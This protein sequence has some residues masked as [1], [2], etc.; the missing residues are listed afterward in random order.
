MEYPG[1]KFNEKTKKYYIDTTIKLNNGKLFHVKYKSLDSEFGSIKYVK[2]NYYRI[3]EEI[4]T[5]KNNEIAQGIN[6]IKKPKKGQPF[7]KVTDLLNEYLSYRANQLRINT[8][9]KYELM[10]YNAIVMPTEDKTSVFLSSEFILK[11]RKSIL[12]KDA[13]NKTKSLYF[14]VA[15]ELITFARKIDLI[16]SDK[17]DD[18]L[19]LLDTKFG[20][21]KK[22]ECANKYTPIEDAYK[23]FDAASNDYY[24][25]LFILLYYSS[26]RIGEFLGILKEDIKECKDENNDVYYEIRINKQRLPSSVL[27]PYLK[28]SVP[29]KYIYYFNKPAEVLKEYLERANLKEKDYLFDKSRTLIK[30][31]LNKAFIKANVPHNTLHGFGR[32]SINTELYKN[33][34]DSKT[35]S[36]LLGQ[37]SQ[38]INEIHYVENNEAIKKAKQIL[39]KIE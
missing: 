8:F 2:Q 3:L 13:T 39:K 34:A 6:N 37:D 38:A 23:V 5:E 10:V 33:G 17:R 16:N 22:S 29:V 31:N 12:N 14:H 11:F 7:Y 26:L 19:E 30:R 32:K 36:A 9:R 28:N 35:R 27:V 18:L 15:K 20:V 21:E 4:K 1:I 25:T 24:R